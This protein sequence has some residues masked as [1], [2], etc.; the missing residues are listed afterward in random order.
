MNKR[1]KEAQAEELATDE[2]G[3]KTLHLI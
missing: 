3:N 1:W 2:H